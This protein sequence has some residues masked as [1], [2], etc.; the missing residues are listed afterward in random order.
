VKVYNIEQG[1]SEW[2]GV[3]AGKITGSGIAKLMQSGRSKKQMFGT[4]AISYINEKVAEIVTGDVVV[5]GG[6][7][8]T[9]WGNNLEKEAI[10]RFEYE[11]F[12]EVKA[13]GFIEVDAYTGCSPDGML[14]GA[15]IEVKCPYNTDNHIETVITGCVPPQYVPQV[16][17]NMWCCGVDTCF[18]ISYDPR[19]INTPKQVKII[20]V[21]K[22]VEYLET[23]LFRL[24]KAIKIIEERVAEFE[25]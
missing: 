25:A 17:F 18:F 15:I 6:S 19:V 20:E 4:G 7:S 16:Q 11:R 24:D 10:R 12:V 5:S 3:R 21:K 14:D 22:N 2:H 9:R 1:T 13:V 23:M 8:A